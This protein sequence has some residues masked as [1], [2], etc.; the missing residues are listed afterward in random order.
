MT[1][2]PPKKKNLL[3]RDIA[4]RPDREI[5]TRIFGKRV[6]NEVDRVLQEKGGGSVSDSH[7]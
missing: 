3:P 2:N 4:K 6:M 1:K 5:M 7:T